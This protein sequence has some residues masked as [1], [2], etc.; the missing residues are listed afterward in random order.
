MI[1]GV[2]SSVFCRSA[3]WGWSFVD[4]EHE[5]RINSRIR[6]RVIMHA[7]QPLYCFYVWCQNAAGHGNT[8]DR[9]YFNAQTGKYGLVEIKKVSEFQLPKLC[10]LTSGVVPEEANDR[11]FSPFAQGGLPMRCNG[12]N[13]LFCFKTDADLLR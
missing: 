10:R 6:L 4:E 2:R 12:M 5:I 13:R 7:T 1:L 11:A 8:I 3:G 9:S